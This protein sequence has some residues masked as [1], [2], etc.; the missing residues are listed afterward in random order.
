MKRAAIYLRVSTVDQH[1]SNQEAEL[2]QA[3]ERASWKITKVYRDQGISGAKGRDKRP[4]FDALCRDA[5][6]RQF[7]VVM[8]WNVDRLGRSLQDLVT[9]LSELHALRIDLFLHQQGLDTTTPAGK[10]MFQM[11]G[12]FA[13]FERSIIQERVRAGLLRAKREGK[14]LGRPP[15]REA[16]RNRIIAALKAPE[17]TEGVRK[18]A[19]RFGVNPSTVQ[20]ISQQLG[21]FDSA[22]ASAM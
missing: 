16:L 2:R 9:F 15:I 7:D 1:T 14:R 4:A 21:P 13:E 17:R 19:A 8:A 6:K 3:A 11:L 20:T 5:T 12:V 18:I 22:N 10:A